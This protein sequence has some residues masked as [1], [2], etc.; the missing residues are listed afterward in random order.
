MVSNT[1]SAIGGATD[2]E[3]IVTVTGSSSSW[4]NDGDLR[5]GVLGNGQLL[6]SDGARVYSESG[7]LAADFRGIGAVTVVGGGSNW[8][9]SDSLTVGNLGT[10]ALS[11]EDG[12]AV[13]NT[14]A[15][16]ANTQVSSGVVSVSGNGSTWTSS[17]TLT[18]GRRNTGE[19]I[20]SDGGKVSNGNASIGGSNFGSLPVT[21]EGIVTVSGSNSAWTTLGDLQIGF[22]GGGE[23]EISNGAAV[24]AVASSIGSQ[25]NSDGIVNI[26][27]LN[28]KWTNT[29]SLFIADNGTGQ[30]TIADGAMVTS[31]IGVV[32]KTSASAGEVTV[33]GNNS[34]WDNAGG[35]YVGGDASVSGG[36]AALHVTDFGK[37]VAGGTLRVWNK[38]QVNQANGGRLVVSTGNTSL[39]PPT[40]GVYVGTGT[41]SGNLEVV[42]GGRLTSTNGWIGFGLGSTGTALINGSSSIW[43][44]SGFL[45]VGDLGSGTLRILNGGTVESAHL[46]INPTN[47]SLDWQKGTIRL[48]GGTVSG[49]LDLD[50]NLSIGS[51][52]GQILELINGTILSSL[53]SYLGKTTSTTGTVTITGN[54][55]QWYNGAS[56]YVGGSDMASG[57]SGVL[58]ISSGAILEVEDTLKFWG[59]GVVTLDGGSITTGSFDPTAGTF[60]HRD[61]T[62]AIVGGNYSHMGLLSINGSTTAARPLLQL[63]DVVQSSSITEI[64]VGDSR[65]GTLTI[66]DG[67][68]LSNTGPSSVGYGGLAV[69][70]VLVEGENSCWTIGQG[71]TVG[72]FAS[73]E[74][75]I[76]N[77]GSVTNTTGVIGR[78]SG[79]TGLVTI[80][81]PDAVWTNSGSLV[82]GS[83][84]SGELS[85]VNGGKVSNT[86]GLIG[87]SS[88]GIGIVT[89]SGIGS[90]WSSSATLQIGA[91]GTGTLSVQNGGLVEAAQIEIHA[92]KGTL[93]WDTQG[94]LRINGGTIIGLHDTNNEISIG[95][96]GGQV[97]ELVNGAMLTSEAG[98]LGRSSG[99]SGTVTVT[100]N[101]IW[102]AG[103]NL[104]VGGS[105]EATGGI[106]SLTVSNGGHVEISDVLKV[107]DSSTFTL[108]GGSVNV[109][110]IDVSRGIFNHRDGTL[111]V[112]GGTFLHNQS[113]LTIRGDTAESNPSLVLANGAELNG[114]S[115]LNVGTMYSASLSIT[116]GSV[117]EN[118]S[119]SS[120]DAS[121]GQPAK[122]VVSGNDSS[123]TS[124]HDFYLGAFGVAG[125]ELIISDGGRFNNS[126]LGIMAYGP[127]SIGM[128]TVIGAGS[129]WINGDH[130]SVGFRGKGELLIADGGFVS[131]DGVMI[132]EV[133]GSQGTVNVTGTDSTWVIN[134]NVIVGNNGIGQLTINDGGNVLSNSSGIGSGLSASGNVLVSGNDSTWMTG[135]LGIA[136]GELTIAAGGLVVSEIAAIGHGTDAEAQVTVADFASTWSNSGNL[137]IGGSQFSGGTGTLL[138]KAGGF[139]TTSS[140]F[141]AEHPSAEGF[142]T[143][144]D[145]GSA[146]TLTGQ[147][148]IGGNTVT[149]LQGGLGTMTFGSGGTVNVGENITL[150]PQATVN[151]DGGNLTA[152]GVNFEGT[153]GQFIWTSGTLHVGTYN[154]N[155]SNPGGTLAPGQSAGSTSVNGN[156]TQGPDATL[157]I[158]IGGL[159]S[160]TQHDVVNVTGNATLGGQ[161]QLAMLGNYV[162]FTTDSFTVLTASGILNG[163]FS[164]AAPSERLATTDG[165]GSFLIH[166]NEGGSFDPNQIVLTDFL[167]AG[168]FNNDGIVSAAD[169]TVWRDT[170]N[171]PEGY[172]AWQRNFGLAYGTGSSDLQTAPVPE[173]AAWQLL[174]AAALI[175]GLFA[176]R[177]A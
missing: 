35:V 110:S 72:R 43:S 74:V 149:G 86:T 70:Y 154:G 128:A 148:S 102:N 135:G 157:E 158:E 12:A 131:T 96:F 21:G 150:F 2:S 65:Y 76:A 172:I 68:H 57:G 7:I 111:T 31:T 3:G 44:N 173:P 34:L 161:L 62:L 45:R 29:G 91:N 127:D 136:R 53:N 51:S 47:G 50:N 121:D 49:L 17:G 69:G 169:Y 73:G 125:G 80:S 159:T 176:R 90:T 55:S 97:F 22:L 114:I 166:Y 160:G 98:Y 58:N 115:S 106:A 164:N 132:A 20:I 104:F 32:A 145:F 137:S 63:V 101:S 177:C 138:I 82:V 108:N 27:G 4:E 129:T 48:N 13:S 11:I 167:L 66:T 25:S 174:L 85:I 116:G 8:I 153:G 81:G 117:L 39:V 130:L 84:G 10:G 24:S 88:N 146:W 133:A 126:R 15:T 170:D 175:A 23:L 162:P 9:N 139:A 109:G 61:G 147:L 52:G 60:N 120:I 113:S 19:L 87:N 16:I 18:V 77:G 95:S 41:G 134:D 99:E 26:T 36:T 156:Y 119:S 142:V 75:R 54:G 28:S 168:D 78:E 59:A 124:G 83:N 71:L 56:L 79:S 37:I 94:T 93:N 163:T 107:W 6:I 30:L 143:V 89:V 123:W 64:R 67:S 40:E 155:L 105:Q 33:T 151:L 100:G 122:V 144:V 42:G 171:S 1:V 5:V 46:Y 92:T 152:L 141:I 38:G 103:S 140:T 165:R 118:A 14:D 112:D